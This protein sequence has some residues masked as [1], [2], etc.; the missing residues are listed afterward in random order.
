MAITPLIASYASF[1]G[2]AIQMVLN[3]KDHP[4]NLWKTLL[5]ASNT[6][7]TRLLSL[8]FLKICLHRRSGFTV[9]Q[10]DMAYLRAQTKMRSI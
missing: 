6:A 3:S 1:K 5:R 7:T 4:K 2:T 8:I 10:Q 9:L